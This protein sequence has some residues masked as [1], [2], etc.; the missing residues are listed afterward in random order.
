MKFAHVVLFLSFLSLPRGTW[1]Q[2]VVLD[3]ER[4]HSPQRW[5]LDLRMGPFLPN[6]D[7]E[8]EG[9]AAPYRE[10]FGRKRSILTQIGLEYQVFQRFGT[11]AVGGTVGYFTK[12]ARAFVDPTNGSRPTERSGDTTRLS[13]Y[14][15]SASLIYRMDVA[16]RRYGFPIV[17]YGKLGLNYSVWT[18]YNGNNTVASGEAFGGRGRGGTL[19][20]HGS[21][22]VSFLLD[23]LDMGSAREFDRDMGVNHTYA[24]FELT[25]IDAKGLGQ[26]NKLHLGGDTWLVGLLFEF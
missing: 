26:K 12:K 13:A 11:L 16:A 15:F 17:P 14:P 1:A 21:L 4:F 7:S 5:A 24:F 10:F 9:G 18:V 2:D 8:F 22:G 20:W 23:V 3:E 19:G 6:V 25:H